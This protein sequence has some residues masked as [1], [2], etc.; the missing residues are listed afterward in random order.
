[1]W[2]VWDKAKTDG[3]CGNNFKLNSNGNGKEQSFVECVLF[4][5]TSLTLLLQRV[6]ADILHDIT[7]VIKR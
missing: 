1:M 3:I 5:S 2:K 4:S 7:D 6:F